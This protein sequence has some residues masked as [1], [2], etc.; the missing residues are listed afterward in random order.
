[1][2]CFLVWQITTRSKSQRDAGYLR[3]SQPLV[4][5]SLYVSTE[6]QISTSS[7]LWV[8]LCESEKFG[9][10]SG[11]VLNTFSVETK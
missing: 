7:N 9:S 11:H 8:G 1:M 10:E 5:L 3:T 4:A 2:S 6:F